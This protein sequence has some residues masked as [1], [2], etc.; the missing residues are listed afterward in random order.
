MH[1]A[2]IT[3]SKCE[4]TVTH[5]DKL[6]PDVRPV[7]G[8]RVVGVHVL[9]G[10]EYALRVQ[11]VVVLLDVVPHHHVEEVP[12]DVVGRRQSFILICKEFDFKVFNLITSLTGLQFWDGNC[13]TEFWS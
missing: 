7:V 13:S 9:D 4:C 11:R 10:V 3:A 6:L 1:P 12:P 2:W 8:V 5:I